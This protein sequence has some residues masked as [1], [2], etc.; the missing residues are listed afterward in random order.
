[1]QSFKLVEGDLVLELGEIVMAEGTDELVQCVKSS[2]GTNKGE[3]FLQPEL[4]IKF[5][6]F[7]EKNLNEEEMR[8]QIRQGLFQEPR[9]KTVDSIKFEHD[10]PNRIMT[11]RFSATAVD[12]TTIESEV[13]Q[14]VG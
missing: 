4:G 13:T 9:I 10:K 2:L 11:V 5:R 7:L 1:M 8:E 3:W 12:G 14:H 6:A